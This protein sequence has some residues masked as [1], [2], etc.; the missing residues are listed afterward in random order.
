MRKYLPVIIVWLL[1]AGLPSTAA[2]KVRV[3]VVRYP[4]GKDTVSGY[5]CL[6][7]V[8]KGKL[9][10][11]IVIHEWWGLNDWVK[12]NAERF[13]GAGYVALAVDLYRGH[14]TSS[15][16]EAHELMRGLPEDRAA[17][18]LTAAADFLKSHERVDPKRIG[19]IG[20]CMGG[21]YSLNTALTVGDLAACVICYGRLVTDSSA[22]ATI[23]CPVLGLFG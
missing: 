6:P 19:S 21:G 11:L 22:A 10:A 2:Q 23:P 7:Q 9:P 14:A 4:S 13:A 5:L 15:P 17:R 3:E 1:A 18:D 12:K 16:D 20:W 8:S